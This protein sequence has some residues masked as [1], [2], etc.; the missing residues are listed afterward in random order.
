[1]NNI[2][3]LFGY[4]SKGQLEASSVCYRSTTYAFYVTNYYI[5]RTNDGKFVEYKMR[6]ERT[7]DDL[8]SKPKITHRFKSSEEL[9]NWLKEK[10]GKFDTEILDTEKLNK[11]IDNKQKVFILKM[12]E[13]SS[14][15]EDIV[16]ASGYQSDR[17]LKA[18]SLYYRG[19]NTSSTLTE[20]Y[21]AKTLDKKYIE[22]EIKL[23]SKDYRLISKPQIT[24]TFESSEELTNWLEKTNTKFNIQ[25]LNNAIDDRQEEYAQS[26]YGVSWD[27]INFKKNIEKDPFDLK[28]IMDTFE[29]TIEPDFEMGR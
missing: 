22:Y 12:H 7:E 5:A 19:I 14:D 27:Q 1:M 6:Y 10:K 24:H 15:M 21:I 16:K 26:I 28:I 9:N 23:N 8:I 18:S 17:Q 20:Y 3:K 29:K 11:I 2:A 25:S 4:Q 13:I